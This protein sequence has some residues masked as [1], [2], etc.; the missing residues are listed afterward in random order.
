MSPSATYS[1]VSL[2]SGLGLSY[3]ALSVL[4]VLYS[5]EGTTMAELTVRLRCSVDPEDTKFGKSV[6]VCRWIPFSEDDW[7]MVEVQGLEFQVWF[8]EDSVYLVKDLPEEDIERHDNI[9]LGIIYL[10]V[11]I[12]DVRNE[13]AEFVYQERDRPRRSEELPDTDE[14]TELREQ[15]KELGQRVYRGAIKVLNRVI[16]YFRVQ[17]GQYWLDRHELNLENRYSFFVKTQ[18]K[19]QVNDEWVRWCPSTRGKNF[20]VTRLEQGRNLSKEEWPDLIEFVRGPRSTPAVLDFLSR[21][22][23]LAEEGY[24]RSAI[25][26]AVSALETALY[27]FARYPDRERL[28]AVSKHG[29]AHRFDFDTL[30]DRIENKFGLSGSLAVLLPI[31]LPTDLLPDETLERCREA[32]SVRVEVV[33]HGRRSIDE[34]ELRDLIRNVRKL[35]ETLLDLTDRPTP[36]DQKTQADPATQFSH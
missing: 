8:D 4:P 11:K 26:E 36:P 29:S 22:E 12:P 33:H 13:L 10:D 25:V 30:H 3:L 31:L 19:V 32:N 6:V 21:A 15:Y 28:D 23:A 35:S 9:P 27:D 17:K 34:D 2:R 5:I 24:N 14:Y 1:S 7:F 20:A 16:D 18:A